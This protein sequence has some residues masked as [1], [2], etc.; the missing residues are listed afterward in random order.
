MDREIVRHVNAHIREA[1]LGFHDGPQATFDFL[2]ECGCARRVSMR[3]S[4]YDAHGAFAVTA[5]ATGHA[6]ESR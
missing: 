1:A 5:R 4:D 3:I 2:C 6:T